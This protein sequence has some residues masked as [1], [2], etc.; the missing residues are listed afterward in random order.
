MS[1]AGGSSQQSQHP[2][3]LAEKG[4][5]KAV[6]DDAASI[7]DAEAAADEQGMRPF[8]LA[9]LSR[10]SPVVV[11]RRS[12]PGRKGPDVYRATIEVPYFGDYPDTEM[13]K[14]VLATPDVR[15]QWDSLVESSE[16][17]EMPDS[18]TRITKTNFRLGWPASPRDAVTV[19]R[20]VEDGTALVDITTSMKSTPDAP[21]YLRPAPPYVRSHI[22]MFAWCVQL[23]KKEQKK[24]QSRQTIRITVFWSWNLKGVWFG[25]PTGGLGNQLQLLL[26]RFIAFA[27][28]DH[29]RI[30]VVQSFGQAIDIEHATFDASRDILAVDYSVLDGS[31]PR[32]GATNFE[33]SMASDEGWDVNVRVKGLGSVA[34]LPKM[35]PQRIQGTSRIVL[36][37]QHDSLR[38]EEVVRTSVTA[39]RIAASSELRINGEVI[40]IGVVP[41]RRKTSSQDQQVLSDVAGLSAIPIARDPSPTPASTGRSHE[42]D[43]VR[44]S[45]Q[46]SSAIDA[47]IRRNYIYFTSLL[48]EPEQKWKRVSES[49]GVTVTQL[50]SIDPTLVVYR[51]EATFVGVGVWDLFSTINTPGARQ[52]WD[53]SAENSQLLADVND[54]SSLWWNRTKAVWPVSARDSVTVQTSYKSTASVHIFSFSTDD[55]RLFPQVPATPMGTIRT[56]VDLRGWSVECLSPTTVHVTLLEQSD[57]KGWTSKSTLPSAMAAAVAGVGEHAIKFGSPP[58]VTRLLGA[59]AKNTKYDHENAEFRFEYELNP[60]ED[61]DEVSE[62]A[63]I[64]CELRCDLEGWSPNLDLV[65]DPPPIHVSCLRRN[66]LS[67]G[68]S[69]LWLTVEHVAASI[70]DDA[71]RIIVRKG[72]ITSQKGL[73]LVNGASIKVDKDELG[74]DPVEE[75]TKRKRNRPQR[76]ALDLTSP[77]YQG[78]QARASPSLGSASSSRPGTP[79]KSGSSIGRA[80]SPAPSIA[81]PPAKDKGPMTSA[82][83]ILFLLR[84]IYA[85]RSPDPAVTPAGWTLVSERAGLHIRRRMMQSLSPTVSIQRSDK[86]VQGLTSEDLLHAISSL[87]MRKHCDDR[88]DSITRLESYGNGAGTFCFSTKPSFPFRGR[89]FEVGHITART[90]SR[91]VAEGDGPPLMPKPVAY[92]YAA[93][94]F[95]EEKVRFPASRLN[96]ATLPTGRVLVEGWILET[97]DPYASTAYEIPSTRCTH[98]TAIDHAGSLPASVNTAWNANL[99]RAVNH[100]ENFLKQ[101]GVPPFSIK[102]PACML[103]LG[104]GR[105]ET[106]DMPWVAR[107]DRLSTLLLT[108]DFDPT[109]REFSATCL[110][111]P[112]DAGDSDAKPMLTSDASTEKGANQPPHSLSRQSSFAESLLDDSSVRGRQRVTSTITRTTSI[113]SVSSAV[114]KARSALL[115]SKYTLRSNILFEFEIELKD[116]PQGYDVKTY[117]KFA[118][119]PNSDTD[120]DLAPG[121]TDLGADLQG[122]HDVP[123]RMLVYD[124]P[125]TA[126]LAASFNTGDRPRRHLVRFVPD[127][128]EEDEEAKKRF[129]SDSLVLH[130]AVSAAQTASNIPE[131]DDISRASTPATVTVTMNKK[132]VEIV[133]VN[134]TSAMLQREDREADPVIVLKK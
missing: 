73:V 104:D 4:K 85:E 48:Q 81:A 124:L 79:I 22:D 127:L 93:A 114:I 37:L 1:R 16:L 59:K 50:D 61:G 91:S 86:I 105:D 21:A 113:S 12:N 13:F 122:Q 92:F 65:I 66:K 60:P 3:R 33:L 118:D 70:E 49:R 63:H 112:E 134:Q 132:E 30:P 9:T 40:D 131:E 39:Q 115:K 18:A 117:T 38:P 101:R 31:K 67:H 55:T 44:K 72:N 46:T 71:A 126:L 5:G 29:Q 52:Q 57:P 96:P 98:I 121:L 82:L 106:A 99:P 7:A 94:S 133:K 123:L 110:H 36:A 26:R 84:R 24:E 32:S 128:A 62:M 130:F 53:K 42:E 51:A 68:A 76:A 120:S 34:S 119:S 28:N 54:L 89:I 102:P 15:G 27:R 80:V 111:R 20:M 56:Q 6:E 23:P 43:E 75:L 74:Q 78:A 108:S 129:S 14:R 19:S 90:A 45:S 64:E 11:H 95:S 47:L 25:L 100:Y 77:A 2:S 58:V 87:Q 10:A 116:F 83:N 41:N 88:I 35:V 103:V 109:R 17:I 125:P 8:R 69:G 107:S 97:M